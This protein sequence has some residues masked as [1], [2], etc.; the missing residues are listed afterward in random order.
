ME[1]LKIKVASHPAVVRRRRE[2]KGFVVAMRRIQSTARKLPK[3][4]DKKG[5]ETCVDV[6]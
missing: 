4:Q 1:R 5:V 2:Q 3:Q 6:G